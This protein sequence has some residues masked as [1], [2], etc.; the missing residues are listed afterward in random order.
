MNKNERRSSGRVNTKGI[1]GK[2]RPLGSDLE[3][4]N[5]L[6]VDIS[7]TGV[8]VI[9]EKSFFKGDQMELCFS[10]NEEEILLQIEV[11]S[12]IQGKRCGSKIILM[13]KK[14]E[15]IIKKYLNKYFL[16]GDI[17]FLNR[18]ID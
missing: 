8:V 9:G 12:N 6:V 14:E 7:L 15:E 1:K 13:H 16:R 10:L 11:T 4:E 3:W 17:S 18:N 5:C 2:C